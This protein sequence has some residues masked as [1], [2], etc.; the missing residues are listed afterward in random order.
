MPHQEVQS[1][2]QVSANVENIKI[3]VISL[4]YC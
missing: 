3:E 2:P 4:T 1:H